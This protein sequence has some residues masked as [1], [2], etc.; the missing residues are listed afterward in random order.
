MERNNNS[1]FSLSIGALP[2]DN[3]APKISASSHKK[4]LYTHDLRAEITET[5]KH[6][7]VNARV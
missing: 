4:D 7:L 6:Q 5:Q 2:V 3:K 1:V